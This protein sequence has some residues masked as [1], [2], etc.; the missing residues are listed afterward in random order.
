M[1]C[2]HPLHG[3]RSRTPSANGKFGVVFNPKLGYVDMPLTVP[4]GQCVGCRLDRSR[5]WAIR[6]SHEAQLH[7]S[8]C[9]IT[10]TYSD[11][12]LPYDWSLDVS[13]FQR[14]MKRLRNRF[15]SGIRF[16]HCGEYGDKY[17]RP[18]Y[19]ACIFGMDFPDKRLHK[20][21][22]NG[23]RLYTS[24]ILSSIWADPD[25]GLTYGHAIIGDVT[26]E[27]AAYVARY[28]MKKVNGDMAQR[29]YEF[30]DPVTGEIFQRKPEYT[31]MSRR[32]GLGK[33][34]YDKFKDDVYPR[35]FIMHKGK[36]LL[37]PKFYDRQYEFSDPSEYSLIKSKRM[38][39]A[40]KFVDDNTPD[41]LSVKERVTLS[42]LNQLTR[43]VDHDT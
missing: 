19:H 24:E 5:Q 39:N 15:G 14:F 22:R 20:V 32:P 16:Y 26:F 9:F 1:P 43:G 18:H 11:E 13:V 4:C 12:W 25:T 6:C 38:I 35:D 40:K 29:H 23:T 34:W 21:E 42:R 41:R 36:K 33:G 27:S 10:L 28:I 8:N 3:F 37:P 17:G 30:V 2:F 7:E 31:T